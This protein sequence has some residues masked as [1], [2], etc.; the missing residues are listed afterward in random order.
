LWAITW[1]ASQA[2]LAA[3]LSAPGY[4]ER[5]SAP[6]AIDHPRIPFPQ[7]EA[8]FD[9][10][11]A[12]GDE[13]GRAHLMEALVGPDVRLEGDGPGVIESPRHDEVT[14]TVWINARQRF[15]GVP[16]D[17]WV[18]GGAFRPLEHF[19]VDRR[20]R[21]LDADQIAMFQSAI[22]AVRESIRLGPL[23]DDALGTILQATMDV[24]I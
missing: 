15:T 12:L 10:M 6:L 8:A 13:L 2:P 20:G 16:S 7:S 11:R 22:W 19:L 9:A 23:L 24:T 21:R 14:E 4:R 3:N 1:I 17:A 18:W 5:F